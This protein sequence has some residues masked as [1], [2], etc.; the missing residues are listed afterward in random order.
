MRCSK[1]RAASVVAAVVAVVVAGAARADTVVERFAAPDGYVRVSGGAAVADGGFGA[2]LRTLPLLPKGAPVLRY[3]GATVAAPWAKAV[4]DINVGDKDLMQCADSAITLYANWRRA[5]GTL[6]GLSFHATSGD[7]MP[8]DRFVAG[9]RVVVDKK[10]L[11]FSPS[12]TPPA[13]KD[14]AVVDD[15]VWKRFMETTYMYAGSIS[16][17]KDTTAVTGDLQP[18]DLLVVGGSPGHVL[19]VLDVAVPVAAGTEPMLLLGQG[20]MPAQSFHVVGWYAPDADGTVTVP[21]W[22]KPFERTSRRRFR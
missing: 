6:K 3:D 2:F 8:L 11:R 13:L 22:P 16:L 14:G 15:A 4:V 21:S 18:G 12:R 19:V 5:R 17:A 20:F 10:G 9:D 7:V 1:P